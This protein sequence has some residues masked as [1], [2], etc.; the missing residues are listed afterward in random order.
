MIPASFDYH[1]PDS[2]AAAV[3]LLSE[4]GE[5]ARV[6]AGGHSLIPMMKLRMAVPEHLVDLRDIAELKGIGV[7]GQ[8]V[9]IGAMTTQA[10]VIGSDA[11][12][13]AC[14]ILREASLQ[15]ADPQIRNLGTLGG[16]VANGDPGN[17]YAGSDADSGCALPGD[18]ARRNPRDRRTG[19]LRGGLLHRPGGGRDPDLDPLHRS[20]GRPR[21]C[22]R[23]SRSARS[24]TMPPPRPRSCW[25]WRT[26]GAG[27]AAI[28]LTNLADTPLLARRAAGD[29]LVGS[30]VDESAID[31]AV[32]ACRGD[33]R[34]GVRR[35]R[36]Q[37]FPHHRSPA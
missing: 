5:E 8:M 15:I 28:G 7:E 4:H 18:R 9:S 24:A 33:H 19:F 30:A 26:A 10:E 29:A 21:L 17:D 37:R 22:L 2:V 27:H 13:Q 32:A 1:R 36:P 11:L 25:R 34:A 16:N 6:V 3:Q 31:A 14:P 20:G 12:A 35:P 23:K